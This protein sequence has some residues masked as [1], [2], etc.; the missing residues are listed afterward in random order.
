MFLLNKINVGKIITKIKLHYESN[1][2]Q[3]KEY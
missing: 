1:Q 3:R 2:V